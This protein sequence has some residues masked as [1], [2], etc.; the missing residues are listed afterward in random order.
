[1]ISYKYNEI[2]NKQMKYA[3]GIQ[4]KSIQLGILLGLWLNQIVNSLFS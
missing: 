2:Y 4:L 1:M 3:T